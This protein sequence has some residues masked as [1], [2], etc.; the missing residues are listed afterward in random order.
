MIQ[1][2]TIFIAHNWSD[3]SVAQQSK[4]LALA[5][6][7][8]NKVVFLSAKK[9]GHHAKKINDNLIV[10]EWPGKR[11]TGMKDF[12]FALKLFKQYN[13]NIA[14]T[15]FAANNIMLLTSWLTGTKV[16]MCYH[17]TLLEQIITDNPQLSLKQRFFLQRKSWIYQLATHL[18]PCSSAAK[19]DLIKHY[20]VSPSKTFVFPNA[21]EDRKI[22]NNGADTNTIG[23][24]GRLDYSK[25]V[26]IL[27]NAFEKVQS[28][29][30]GARLVIVGDGKQHLS[31]QQLAVDKKVNVRFTGAVSY[32]S[33]FTFLQTFTCLAVPSRTDNLPTVILESF[34]CCT[35][36]VASNAGGIPDMIEDGKNGLLFEKENT[37]N[38]AD[39][40]ITLL[41]DK[42]ARSR[43]AENAR[44]VFLEKYCVDTLPVRI[45]QLLAATHYL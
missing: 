44:A 20:K 35:P 33:V 36:V 12:V 9:N 6:S 45:E 7:Q 11:P 4:A 26:D 43:F 25:G 10:Y 13:P 24:I 17:H 37:A 5:F 3:A 23:F 16:R 1:N 14:I 39:K 34:S 31:L 41:G 21:L 8:H 29:H 40:L 30:P 19:D 32:Q 2:K 38:L 42:E 18:L 28:F 27:I 22:K 15:N